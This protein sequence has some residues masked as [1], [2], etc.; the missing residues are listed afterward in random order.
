MPNGAEALQ[1]NFETLEKGIGDIS[2][3]GVIKTPGVETDLLMLGG[4]GFMVA[5]KSLES[6]LTS[7]FKDTNKSLRYIIQGRVVT[8][9]GTIFPVRDIT[10][11]K[12]GRFAVFENLPFKSVDEQVVLQ[13]SPGVNVHDVVFMGN[14]LYVDKH[15]NGTQWATMTKDWGLKITATFIIE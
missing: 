7:N 12:G 4:R 3:N 14:T 15:R 11:N 10:E 1:E 5:P 9:T 8:I 2:E 13:Q 6:F